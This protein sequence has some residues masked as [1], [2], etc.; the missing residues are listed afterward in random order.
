MKSWKD[1]EN[2]R[3]MWVFPVLP[4]R[5]CVTLEQWFNTPLNHN[6]SLPPKAERGQERLQL[7]PLYKGIGRSNTL[8]R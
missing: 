8:D 4:Q 1:F 7:L 3:E 5:F 2:E 6:F